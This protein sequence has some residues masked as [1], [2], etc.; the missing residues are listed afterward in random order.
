MTKQAVRAG[1]HEEFGQR[2][3]ELKAA[4]MTPAQART[5]AYLEIVVPAQRAELG[6]S[7]DVDWRVPAAAFARG[8]DGETLDADIRSEVEWVRT[9]L[10][11]SDVKAANSPGPGAWALYHWVLE[12]PA[13]RQIFY[14][15]IYTKLIP[16]RS[17][18]DKEDRFTDDGSEIDALL[19]KALREDARAAAA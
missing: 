12:N 16:S 18:L 1:K 13:H 19:V 10:A 7:E 9:H 4:G 14:T 3:D 2:R 15:Q 8:E 6:M 11:I 5:Q 17:Q